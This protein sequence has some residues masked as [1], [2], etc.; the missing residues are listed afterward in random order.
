MLAKGHFNEDQPTFVSDSFGAV[1]L[2]FGYGAVVQKIDEAVAYLGPT[3]P[4]EPIEGGGVTLEAVIDVEDK[5]D[6]RLVFQAISHLATFH[7]GKL[8]IMEVKRRPPI[9]LLFPIP[10]ANVRGIEKPE[11]AIK[12]LTTPGRRSRSA[13]RRRGA[14]RATR[15]RA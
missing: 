4:S 8:V 11:K 13:S 3:R 2:Y 14:A 5:P 9:T 15:R 10:L 12:R 7:G 6:P 1:Q